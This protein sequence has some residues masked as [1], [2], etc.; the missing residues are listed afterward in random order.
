MYLLDTNILS[1]LM[2]IRPH[3]RVEA[4]FESEPSAL[5]T[6]AICLE[7]IRFGAGVGPPGNR[8]WE[9]AETDVLPFVTVLSFDERVARLAGD[10]RADWKRAGTP[11]GYP[12][13]LIAATA[14][15]FGLTLVT[16][17]TRHFDHVNG[18]KLDNWFE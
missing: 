10:L 9:R 6:A 16:R 15:A 1:E 17:N 12:D 7:E 14:K 4:R 3:S 2:R 13:G 8:L 18:L 5:F 11:T